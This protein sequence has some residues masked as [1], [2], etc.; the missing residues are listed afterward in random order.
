LLWKIYFYKKL[1]LVQA[2]AIGNITISEDNKNTR[3][4][5]FFDRNGFNLEILVQ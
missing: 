3:E 4:K 1:G 5:R 2:V